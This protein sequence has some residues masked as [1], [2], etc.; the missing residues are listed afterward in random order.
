[1]SMNVIFL[2]VLSF[3]FHHGTQLSNNL[4]KHMVGNHSLHVTTVEKTP[5]LSASLVACSRVQGEVTSEI[6][7]CRLELV[8]SFA[9]YTSV[10]SNPQAL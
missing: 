8:F 10:H 1:M 5:Y 2:C 7:M 9:C 3:I 6:S 4:I